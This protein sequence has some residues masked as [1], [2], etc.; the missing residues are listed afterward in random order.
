LKRVGRV[1]IEQNGSQIWVGGA[2]RTCVTGKLM[3]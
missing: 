1:H 3:V 2:V